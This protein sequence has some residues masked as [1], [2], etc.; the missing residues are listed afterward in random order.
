MNAG[1]KNTPSKHHPRRRNI[2][3]WI[4]KKQPHTQNLTQTGEPQRYSW[5]TQKKKKK[6]NKTKKKK[7]TTTTKKKKMKKKKRRKKKKKE[8]KKKKTKKTTTKT[9]KKKNRW[10][11]FA[12]RKEILN[13]FL[14]KQ[15]YLNYLPCFK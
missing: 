4:K 9:T 6:K 8:K 13:I 3:G 14:R 15:T 5:G 1:D 2:N 12:P 11:C 10:W 7:T